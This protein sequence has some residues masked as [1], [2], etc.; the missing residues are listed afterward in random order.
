MADETIVAVNET[1]VE[2]RSAEPVGATKKTRAP[3]KKAEP[4]PAKAAA[5]PAAKTTRAASRPEKAAKAASKAAPAATP[6]V[7]NK[8]N[9]Y[10]PAQRASILASIEKATKDGKTTLKAALQQTKVS[11]QTYYNWKNAAT[12]KAPAP[13]AG[14]SSDDLSSLVAL[15]AENLK[16]RQELA[17]KLRAENEELRRRLGRT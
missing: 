8:R 4:R 7:E 10:T 12:K 13:S 9:K 16:L 1:P 5:A 3:R 15:E 2:V 6:P 17:A 14:S 11:E